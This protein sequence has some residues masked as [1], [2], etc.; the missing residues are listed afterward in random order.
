MRYSM[1]PLGL[2]VVASAASC[3]LLHIFWGTARNASAYIHNI[4]WLLTELCPQVLSSSWLGLHKR[5]LLR[6]FMRK[7]PLACRVPCVHLHVPLTQV[8]WLLTAFL[9]RRALQ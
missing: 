4:H 1:S 8:S 3:R 6:Y 5:K 9:Q 2:L 7:C